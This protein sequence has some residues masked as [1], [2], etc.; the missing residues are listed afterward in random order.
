MYQDTQRVGEGDGVHV[1]AST[2]AVGL[3]V[4]HNSAHTF[5]YV[6]VCIYTYEV[7]VKAT[8]GSGHVLY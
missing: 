6:L 1:C 7:K 3:S 4:T 5:V 8:D 2:S